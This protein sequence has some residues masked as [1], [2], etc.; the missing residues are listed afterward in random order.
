M[1]H[2]FFARV[3]TNPSC[4]SSGGISSIENSPRELTM[5]EIAMVSGGMPFV[6]PSIDASKA[7]AA[8]GR[9]VGSYSGKNYKGTESS[10]W[11]GLSSVWGEEEAACR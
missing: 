9:S 3:N 8:G 1:N 11:C 10:I 2:L 6:I 4:G 5:A 7:K